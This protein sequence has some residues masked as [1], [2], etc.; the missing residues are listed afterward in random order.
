MLRHVA[1][2]VPVRYES[3]VVRNPIL[4]LTVTEQR[5]EINVR[6]GRKIHLQASTAMTISVTNP[7]LVD[8][9]G[10]GG[11]PRLSRKCSIFI[12]RVDQHEQ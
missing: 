10:V 8:D 11:F 6:A 2:S 9:H 12:F 4:S 1:G 3:E 7:L 5:M